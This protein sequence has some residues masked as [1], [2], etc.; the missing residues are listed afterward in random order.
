M[1]DKPLLA[2]QV[3]SIQFSGEMHKPDC[4]KTEQCGKLF[5]QARDM[6][7]LNLTDMHTVVGG[8]AW[9]FAQAYSSPSCLNE[10]LLYDL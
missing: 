5:S 10:L 4:S 9:I 2:T 1:R 7:K 3:L 6:K 8:C